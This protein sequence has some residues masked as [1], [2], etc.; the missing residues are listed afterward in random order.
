MLTWSVCRARP[1]TH[2]TELIGF[3]RITATRVSP[4]LP[5][6]GPDTG[7][8]APE[9]WIWEAS[10][11]GCQYARGYSA[12][13]ADARRDAGAWF[14][15]NIDRITESLRRDRQRVDDAIAAIGA[16]ID[17]KKGL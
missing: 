7:F 5:E 8:E 4:P 12:S 17:K 11:P 1:Y 16:Y 15:K 9:V 10:E 13:A 6:C 2:E 3:F 14:D